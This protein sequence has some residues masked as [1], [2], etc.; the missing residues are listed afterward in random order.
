M[1]LRRISIMRAVAEPSSSTTTEVVPPHTPILLLD[2]RHV[3]QALGC[4]RSFV[5][6]L[7]GAGE[8]PVVKL[9][10]LTRIPYKSVEQYVERKLSEGA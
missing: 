1:P 5:Y 7:V 9:G 3:A 10:R 2:V 4:G 6:E 8:L